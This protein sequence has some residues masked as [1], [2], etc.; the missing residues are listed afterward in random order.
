[1]Q[2]NYDS[3]RTQVHAPMP[4]CIALIQ[5]LRVHEIDPRLPFAPFFTAFKACALKAWDF[6]DLQKQDSA[7]SQIS[8]AELQSLQES[9]YQE[10][11]PLYLLILM[12]PTQ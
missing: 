6:S 12:A 7:F 4:D 8:L 5:A 3:I 11:H 9:F 1:M 10:L 2:A